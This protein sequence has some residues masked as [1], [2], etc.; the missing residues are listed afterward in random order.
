MPYGLTNKD[1]KAINSVFEANP[2]IE[3]V[4]LYGS[5]AMGTFRNGS[6][7]DLTLKG[8][9]IDLSKQLRIENQLDDLLLPYK[10]DISTIN[11]IE[12]QDLLE[13]IKKVGKVFYQKS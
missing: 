1:I 4:I 13:H 12:N 11:K 10:M 2:E 3:Q 5:R 8:E 6:D 9:D 7:I